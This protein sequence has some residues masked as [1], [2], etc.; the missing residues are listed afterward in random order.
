MQ[1]YTLQLKQTGSEYI[2]QQ[3][4]YIVIHDQSAGVVQP[5][6]ITSL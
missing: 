1:I 5:A 6:T 4:P 2:T 3:L